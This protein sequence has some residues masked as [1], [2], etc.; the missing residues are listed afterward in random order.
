M[1]QIEHDFPSGVLL[2]IISAFSDLDMNTSFFK[3]GSL[4]F[5]VIAVLNGITT[6]DGIN[7]VPHFLHI[8]SAS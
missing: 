4:R 2:Q 7:F 8:H 5:M 3:I 6:G 1:P